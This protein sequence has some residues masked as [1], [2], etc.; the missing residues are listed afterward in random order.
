MCVRTCEEVGGRLGPEGE[1]E[2][3]RG[4]RES[5]MVAE[6]GRGPTAKGWAV[7]FTSQIRKLLGRGEPLTRR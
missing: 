7:L 2:E 6:E 4:E 5:G 1:E 3:A